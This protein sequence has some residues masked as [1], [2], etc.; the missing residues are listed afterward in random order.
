MGDGDYGFD[1]N[2]LDVDDD[3]EESDRA[4]RHARLRRARRDHRRQD[5]DRRHHPA[6]QR[7]DHGEPAS[8]P[9][10]DRLRALVDGSR[11]PA[12]RR[13][14]AITTG[15]LFAGAG[16]WHRGQRLPRRDRRRV[17]QSRRLRPDRRAGDQPLPD[18]RRRPTPPSSASRSPRPK[19]ARCSRKPIEMMS[20]ARGQIRQPL[21][22]RAQVT[23]SVVDTY[24][25]VLG[26]VRAP[27]APVFGTDVSL[28]K[29][30]TVAFFSNPLAGRSTCQRRHRS[31]RCRISCQRARDLLRRSGRAD[32][33]DRL[34]RAL[35]RQYFAALF[36]RRRSRP[37]R[38]GRSRGPIEDFS[39]SRDRAAVG[40]D[41]VEPA[42]ARAVRRRP[43]VQRHRAA[44]HLAAAGTDRTA[45]ACQRHA[46]ILRRRADL[47]RQHAG[48]R[49]RR[50]RRRHRPGRHD[51]LPWR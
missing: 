25:A 37:R 34:R 47:P 40:S 36:P 49:D 46:D 38:R 23:I 28:Q 42:A 26:M 5:R 41:Q 4:R 14:T 31:P 39:P 1:P 18:P 9:A 48:R 44:M 33:P 51:Q 43:A 29:A 35:D 6:L 7:R 19:C 27:D 13:S 2:V 15:P 10:A 24:G 22:S 3:A 8:T 16:L 45:P 32:R 50:V 12:G 11:G 21:D 30:R 20:R 17:R